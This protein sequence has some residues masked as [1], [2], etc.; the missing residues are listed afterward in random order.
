MRRISLAATVG[1]AT[2]L[3]SSH[4]LAGKDLDAVKARGVL[5][6]GVAAGGLAGF[7]LAGS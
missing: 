7:M 4:A 3:M 2:A 1:L 5:I 6:C